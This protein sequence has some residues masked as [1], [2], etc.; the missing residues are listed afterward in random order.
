MQQASPWPHLQLVLQVLRL[1][2]FSV[3]NVARRGGGGFALFTFG[4]S[5][6]HFVILLLSLLRNLLLSVIRLEMHQYRVQSILSLPPKHWRIIT[7]VI[8]RPLNSLIN[9][10]LR[11]CQIDCLAKGRWMLS[12]QVNLVDYD[13]FPTRSLSSDRV[14]AKNRCPC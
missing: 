12:I 1:F 2:G 4:E 13:L 14:N 7:L 5:F 6:S 11:R 8:T 3:A 10:L 9:Y